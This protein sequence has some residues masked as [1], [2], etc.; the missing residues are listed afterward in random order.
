MIS[1]FAIAFAVTMAILAIPNRKGE[2]PRED[3]FIPEVNDAMLGCSQFVWIF[4]ALAVILAV[5]ASMGLVDP[6]MEPL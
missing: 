6:T 2:P 3:Q 4:L 5:A 1:V